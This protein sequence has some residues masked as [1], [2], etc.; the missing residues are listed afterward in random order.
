MLRHRFI[1]LEA[2]RSLANLACAAAMNRDVLY[3][4]TRHAQS[5]LNMGALFHSMSGDRVVAFTRSPEIAW[6]WASLERDHDEGRGAILIFDRQSLRSRY[7]IEQYHDPIW[8]TET[9]YNDEMEERIW[10]NVVDVGR[11][12]IGFV[13]DKATQCSRE[14]RARN[15]AYRME[16]KARRLAI[17]AN[18][19]GNPSSILLGELKAALEKHKRDIHDDG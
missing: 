4:G 1:N 15:L 18:K 7:K 5:I 12:L 3:H 10:D 11:H 14:V 13:S 17:E 9:Y 2:E 6:Y 16:I 19:V 8:D